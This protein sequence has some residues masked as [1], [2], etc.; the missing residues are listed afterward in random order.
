MSQFVV[1][2]GN[3]GKPPEADGRLDAPAFHRNHAAIWSALAPH[4]RGQTGDVLEVGSGT[5][6]H[7]V[8]F[9]RQ[10]P[11]LV[12]WPSDYNDKHLA[13]IAAWQRHAHLQNIRAPMRIDLSDPDWGLDRHELPPPG[14]LTAILCANILHIA[15]WRV[16]EGLL[17]GAARYLRPDG[18]LFV[19]GP[20]MRNGRHT[21]PSNAAFDASL[22]VE[23]AE[24][25]VRD[26]A[27]LSALAAASGLT[28]AEI[29]QMPAN[30]LI[31]IF[32]RNR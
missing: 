16:S 28:L 1:E 2:Y 26:V 3:V 13:S 19:Y 25:G 31:L 17:G 14:R 9:A 29:V 21:A 20:F 27:D 11:E 10:A 4:L 30:N 22:R 5:G 15:P 6:Q 12:W 24:W 23:N 8:E 18:R 32:A 7:I